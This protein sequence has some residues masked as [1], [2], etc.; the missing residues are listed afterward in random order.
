MADLNGFKRLSH[1]TPFLQVGGDASSKEGWRIAVAMID[2][3]TKNHKTT[4]AIA[5]Q[6]D[7][8]TPLACKMLLAMADRKINTVTSTST[9][10][11]FDAVSALLGI[12]LHSTFEERLPQHCSFV[13]R[14]MQLM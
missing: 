12:R 4:E 1:I 11:L 10:R 9:G 7:L 8:C 14:L 13:R 6:L 3:I 2:T 5:S